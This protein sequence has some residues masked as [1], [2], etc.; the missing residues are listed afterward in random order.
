MAAYVIGYCE[1]HD[2]IKSGLEGEISD[3]T[4]CLNRNP[5][6]VLV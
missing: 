4:F 1:L 5:K 6:I 3:P 2:A